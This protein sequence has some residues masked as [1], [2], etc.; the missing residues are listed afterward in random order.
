MATIN[1]VTRLSNLALRMYG[2]YL[3]MGFVKNEEDK[4]KVKLFFKENLADLEVN[5][6]STFG[7]LYY[8][9]A[10]CWYYYILQDFPRYY[11]HAYKWVHLF[12]ENKNFADYDLMMYLKA[13]H[14]LLS[15][16]FMLGKYDEF[17]NSLKA[18]EENI[19]TLGTDLNSNLQIE[20]FVYVYIAKINLHFLEGTFTQGLQLIP[21]I[22][23]QLKN[24]GQYLDKHRIMIFYYKIACLYF[25]SAR[26]SKSIQY[27]NRIIQLNAGHLRS[28]I[29][30]FARILH[31]ICHYEL[32][33]FDIL[34]Y[35]V[36]SIYKFLLK[37][38][39]LDEIQKEILK[40]LRKILVTDPA[41][42][43]EAFIDLKNKLEILAENTYN[44]RSY[45]YL[46]IIGWLESKIENTPVENIS[47]RKFLSKKKRKIS[48]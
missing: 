26:Y 40:F 32:K 39:Y 23:E 10:H 48:I 3:E 13:N 25:G 8:H 2:L 44:R 15:A 19:Q 12:T 46:D 29:Q 20:Q 1:D 37:M 21:E 34:D 4:R 41:L 35:L 30:C 45:S 47:Q 31:L 6:I 22:E 28:D 17:K 14:Y 24:F 27:L 7:S 33:H 36:K 18:F 43:R 11:K 5:Q 38:E 42:H 9:Q 16:L